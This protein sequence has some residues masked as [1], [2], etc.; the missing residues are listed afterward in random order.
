MDREFR[1]KGN[2]DKSVSFCIWL[3][4]GKVCLPWG[5]TLLR[6]DIVTGEGVRP[7]VLGHRNAE[8]PLNS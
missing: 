2:T 6:K 7:R 5:T 1:R 8:M 3:S 4:E